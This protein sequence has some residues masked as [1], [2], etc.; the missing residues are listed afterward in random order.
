MV[1]KV[2]R[3]VL[4]IM[5][6]MGSSIAAAEVPHVFSAGDR[7][8]AE[9]INENFNSI[10]SSPPEI[11]AIE[12]V[13]DDGVILVDLVVSDKNDLERLFVTEFTYGRLAVD[14]SLV[15]PFG[16]SA[17][18][19]AQDVSEISFRLALPPSTDPQD[20]QFGLHISDTRGNTA[21]YYRS[22]ERKSSSGPKSGFYQVDPVVLSGRCGGRYDDVVLENFTFQYETYFGS[23]SFNDIFDDER[24]GFTVMPLLES[25]SGGSSFTGAYSV[26][27]SLLGLFPSCPIE[28]SIEIANDPDYFLVGPQVT[29]TWAQFAGTQISYSGVESGFGQYCVDMNLST[30][31]D[32]SSGSSSRYVGGTIEPLNENNVAVELREICVVDGEVTTN[33]YSFTGQRAD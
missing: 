25:H 3:T 9:E 1:K 18:L 31:T 15:S 24:D 27:D 5:L 22:A 7:V 14:S 10:D 17:A 11:V 2:P 33:V 12:R 19:I 13:R 4:G 26:P 23:S 21:K 20:R 32:G 6:L 16:T 30:R 8:I 28:P 29:K